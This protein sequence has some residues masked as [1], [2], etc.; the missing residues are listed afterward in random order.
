MKNKTPEKAGG[1]TTRN[2][3][4]E[5]MRILCMLLI[6]SYHFVFE[7]NWNAEG[8]GI[9]RRVSEIT[10]NTVFLQCLFMNGKWTCCAF[11]L[12]TG[13]FTIMA[14][15]H[16]KRIAKIILQFCFYSWTIVALAELLR[17]GSVPLLTLFKSLFPFFYGQWFCMWY[18]LFSFFVP[19]INRLLQGLTKREHERFICVLLVIWSIVPSLAHGWTDQGPLMMFLAMYVIGAYIRLYAQ[20]SRLERLPWK[21]MALLS[22]ALLY[23][24]VFALDFC[25]V[26][27]QMDFFVVQAT[28]FGRLNSVIAVACAISTFM[29]FR[30]M[31][32]HSKWINRVA[33]AT[34]GIYL[35]HE[36]V[37]IK[38]LIWDKWVPGE[39]YLYSP[40]LP[41]VAIGKAVAVF[42]VCLLLEKGREWLFRRSVDKWLDAVWAKYAVRRADQ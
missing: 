2:S 32:F 33:G 36:N 41:V 12:V 22:F 38:P 37:N 20:G 19:F 24:S 1:G 9:I 23:G 25:G 15:I 17:P 29:V 35:I 40:W 6:I 28:Y 42:V 5:L 18:I 21:R 7:T 10:P 14:H 16:Y 31:E 27:V 34:L 3:S 13:Y 8:E 39:R 30:Q 11:A 26:A 4:F